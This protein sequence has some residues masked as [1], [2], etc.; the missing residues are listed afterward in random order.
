MLQAAGAELEETGDLQVASVAQRAGV[1]A[2]LPFRYFGTRSGMLIA[3]VEEYFTRLG[4]AAALREYDDP[5][6]EQRERRRV[7]DWVD[8]LYAEPLSAVVLGGLTGDAEVAA[9]V[10]GHLR[11]LFALGGG[12]IARAQ[13]TGELPAGRDPE[14]L[15]AATVGGLHAIVVVALNR[16]PRPPADVVFDQSWAFVA[17]ALGIAPNPSPA[18]DPGSAR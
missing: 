1:S 3:V 11:S 13:Q 2:G 14:L 5:R 17:G 6:W 16:D 12:N 7:R 4:A 8:F 10:A 18:T 9:A 15:A